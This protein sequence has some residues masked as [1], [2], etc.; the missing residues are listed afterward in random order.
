M[1]GT[2]MM[3]RRLRIARLLLGAALFMFGGSAWTQHITG[4]GREIR[5]TLIADGID[6]FPVARDSFVRQLNS[7]VIV[8][9]RD[10]VV[11]DTDTRPSS[12]TA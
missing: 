6:Q 11:F 3:I 12:G 5:K 1:K 10:V 4:A 7:V 9:E 2:L 8:K